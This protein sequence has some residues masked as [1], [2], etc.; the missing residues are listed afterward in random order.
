MSLLDELR[1]VLKQKRRGK[2]SGSVLLL[3]DNALAY[4][5]HETLRKTRVFGLELADHPPHS[6]DMASSD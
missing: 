5:T 3:Q 6:P 4:I 1:E 2:L